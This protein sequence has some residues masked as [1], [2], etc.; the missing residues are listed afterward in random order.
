[1]KEASPRPYAR[2]TACCLTWCCQEASSGA[3]CAARGV[4]WR[5]VARVRCGT[6]P[7]LVASS[8]AGVAVTVSAT[9][10]SWPSRSPDLATC[11]TKNFIMPGHQLLLLVLNSELIFNKEHSSLNFARISSSFS[12]NP[13]FEL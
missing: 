1:M 11:S 12:S 7:Y 4:T 13:S 3:S 2:S 9:S 8:G 5:S 10:S 6:A